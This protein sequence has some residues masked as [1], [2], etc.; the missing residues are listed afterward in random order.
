MARFVV[1]AYRSIMAV[2]VFAAVVVQL[3]HAVTATPAGSAANFFSLFAIE[4][5]ILA[6]AVFLVGAV[7]RWRPSKPWYD[8]ARGASATYMSVTGLVYAALLSD[9]P[10]SVDATVPWV[11][12]V[13]HYLMPLVVFLDWLF[14]PPR[15]EVNLRVAAWWTAFPLG[16]A[17]YSLIRGAVVHWYP[18]PFLDVDLHG[19]GS[20]LINL[21]GIGVGS[22]VFV[23]AIAWLGN[24]MQSGRTSSSRDDASAPDGEAA[25]G[26]APA[27]DV[28]DGAQPAPSSA[29]GGA[30][31]G[32]ASGLRPPAAPRMDD[33]TLVL[34]VITPRSAPQDSLQPARPSEPTRSDPAG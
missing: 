5:N 14:V 27:V 8:G 15:R 4:A 22:M 25:S 33:S 1:I 19:Y 29:T 3:V 10:A 2:L 17:L 16:Y 6:A 30:S 24:A 26:D 12:E 9:V 18:Y 34:P 28:V 32:A 31:L 20:V 23:A 7:P 13:L 21:I 11:N